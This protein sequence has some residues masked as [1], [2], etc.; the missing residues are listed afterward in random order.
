[1]QKA[2]PHQTPN[3]QSPAVNHLTCSCMLCQKQWCGSK[4]QGNGFGM[5]LAHA[6]T[7]PFRSTGCV[8]TL[9]ISHFSTSYKLTLQSQREAALPSLSQDQECKPSP[10]TDLLWVVCCLGSRGAASVHPKGICGIGCIPKNRE[11][12]GQLA[13]ASQWVLSCEEWYIKRG[14]N[15]VKPKHCAVLSD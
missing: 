4:P 3:E 14:W 5:S 11:L 9:A 12:Q 15:R 2:K 10:P 6:L 1:M 13:L 7:C 8:C